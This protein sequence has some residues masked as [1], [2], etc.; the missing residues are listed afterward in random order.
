[1]SRRKKLAHC[2]YCGDVTHGGTSRIDSETPVCT[3]CA[4]IEAVDPQKAFDRWVNLGGDRAAALE[5]ADR[6]NNRSS[7]RFPLPNR[8]RGVNVGG[9]R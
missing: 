8:L 1:M 5:F 3:H 7:N 4:W 2:F 9:A 6:V